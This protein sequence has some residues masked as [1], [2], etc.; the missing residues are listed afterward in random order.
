MTSQHTLEERV[1]DLERQ[2]AQLR[3]AQANGSPAK[4]WRRTVGMFTGDEG[5]MEI[6]NEAMKIRERDRERARRRYA[7][8][9]RTK[10]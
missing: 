10:K 7:T 1:A 5:M 4:D 6:F 2:V 9:R 3:Q 8:R